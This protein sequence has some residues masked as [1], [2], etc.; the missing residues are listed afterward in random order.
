MDQSRDS[1]AGIDAMEQLAYA[2]AEEM[3]REVNRQ[4]GNEMLKALKHAEKGQQ[5]KARAAQAGM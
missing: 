3:V 4:A 5:A 1:E 2:I